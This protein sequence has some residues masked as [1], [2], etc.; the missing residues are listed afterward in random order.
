MKT[1]AKILAG[2]AILA[3]MAWLAAFLYWHVRILG[4]LRALETHAPPVGSKEVRAE[5]LDAVE[6]LNDAGCRS[7]PYLLGSMDSSTSPWEA[8]KFLFRICCLSHESGSKR[9]DRRFIPASQMQEQ[10]MID[11]ADAPRVRREKIDRVRAWWVEA[12]PE[13]HQ[14]WRIWSANC[15]GAR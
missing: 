3:V 6:L 12:G 2:V 9:P 10:G 11:P 15:R 5:Y 7:L 13:Y 4:I 14:W 8:S 1:A